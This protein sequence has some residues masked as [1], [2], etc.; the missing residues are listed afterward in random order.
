MEFEDAGGQQSA[1]P[2]SDRIIRFGEPPVVELPKSVPED[3]WGTK[4]Q[5]DKKPS[6]IEEQGSLNL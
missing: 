5:K 6:A 4:G 2:S 1:N 3:V